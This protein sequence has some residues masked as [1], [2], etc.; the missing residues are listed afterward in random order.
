MRRTL[1][2]EPARE[3]TSR[4]IA[5][6]VG[7]LLGALATWCKPHDIGRVIDHLHENKDVYL[8]QFRAA[9]EYGKSRLFNA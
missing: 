4:E 1:S 3:L 7:G 2:T 9:N 6:I 8:G 5:K